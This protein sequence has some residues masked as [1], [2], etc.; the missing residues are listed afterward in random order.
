MSPL[1]G[2]SLGVVL[3]QVWF[4]SYRSEDKTRIV[5]LAVFPPPLSQRM[6]PLAPQK[7]E[8]PVS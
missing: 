8:S 3:G 7:P 5:G 6:G 4:R 2:L 1:R